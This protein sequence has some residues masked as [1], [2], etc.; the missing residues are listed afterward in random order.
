MLTLATATVFGAFIYLR[1]SGLL[2]W[3]LAAGDALLVCASLVLMP[4]AIATER[5]HGVKVYL[6]H[7]SLRFIHPKD[8]I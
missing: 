7:S 6:G 5:I 4:V 1:E 8:N 3:P 2:P